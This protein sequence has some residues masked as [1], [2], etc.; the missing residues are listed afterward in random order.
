MLRGTYVGF[1]T[2]LG[3][4]E[5]FRA[6]VALGS[7]EERVFLGSP[8]ERVL[9]G[10]PE[11]NLPLLRLGSTGRWVAYVQHR[12]GLAPTGVYDGR[13]E[14]RVRSVQISRGLAPTGVTDPPTWAAIL[15]GFGYGQLADPYASYDPYYGGYGYPYTTALFFRSGGGLRASGG[16]GGGG[17]T[18]G[19]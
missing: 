5:E 19:Q 12:L 17:R 1:T 13:T 16:S 8:E 6:N 9:L 2:Y 7:P 10:S 4:P 11:E 3:S 18:S 14:A 15:G